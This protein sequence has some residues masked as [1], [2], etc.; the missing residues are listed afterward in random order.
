[1]TQNASENLHIFIESSMDGLDKMGNALLILEQ[2]PANPEP[3][4]EITASCALIRV[5]SETN[6]FTE[7]AKLAG[8]M[9]NVFE[10]LSDEQAPINSEL[11]DIIFEAIE[12]LRTLI[13]GCAEPTDFA[14]DIAPIEKKL[15][16]L[17]ETKNQNSPAPSQSQNTAR[18]EGN[19]KASPKNLNLTD[20]EHSSIVGAFESGKSVALLE[21]E[22]V[23]DCLLKGPRVFMIL[24]TLD[25]FQCD[26]IKSTPDIGE[27]ENEKFDL[28]FT[29][30]IATSSN[31][32]EISISIEA[33]SEIA[34][35]QVTAISVE[36][37]NSTVLPTDILP[38][39]AP[40]P[41]LK[42]ATDEPARQ[43]APKPAPV[44]S[45][46]PT[47]QPVA[48]QP[49]QQPERQQT[50]NT[51][52]KPI[53]KPVAQP[54]QPAPAEIPASISGS[55]PEVAEEEETKETIELVQLV[56]FV[57]AGETYALEIQQV[58]A[59]INMLPIAR[60]PKA[61][62]HIDGVI[63]LRGEIVPVINTRQRL[64]LGDGEHKSSNQIVILSF[65]E[66]KVKAGFL[67]DSVHE[68]IRLPETAIEPPSRVSESVDIEYLRGVGKIGNKIIIL[69]NAHRIV[70]GK[71]ADN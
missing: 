31:L 57:M 16:S 36:D 56:T 5:M 7:P 17:V 15:F 41:I 52:A 55:Y 8:S 61:P 65:E 25:D 28:S 62:A 14:T 58:E 66:E 34:A 20:Y 29:M 33:I 53:A 49:R 23:S 30:L 47:R 45:P 13:N 12:L 69:L 4:R 11:V 60:V 70:F 3:L 50:Q 26:I 32:R 54:A 37:F 35:A 67:V 71:K 42:Q 1:M 39:S 6:G 2:N 10:K 38:T 46:P 27:L 19:T 51:I 68:V 40:A 24:R 9:E 21:V 43:P 44:A 22:I 59:I 48:P 64:K 63:N 18:A